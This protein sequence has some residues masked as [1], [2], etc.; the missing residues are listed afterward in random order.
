MKT[1]VLVSLL[2]SIVGCTD[3]VA[4]QDKAKER[5]ARWK[6]EAYNSAVIDCE[7]KANQAGYGPKTDLI[8]RQKFMKRCLVAEGQTDE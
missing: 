7:V 6:Q 8:E 4:Q 1:V 3:S 2:L 5:K